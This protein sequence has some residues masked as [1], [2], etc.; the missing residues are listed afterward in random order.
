MGITKELLE[1][2]QGIADGN[3]TSFVVFGSRASGRERFD[4]DLDVMLIFKSFTQDIK[5]IET[6]ISDIEYDISS[7]YGISISSIQYSEKELKIGVERRDRL[8]L[9]MITGYKVIYDRNRFF[10]F[11]MERLKTSLKK[12]GAKY[13][14]KE[15]VWKIPRLKIRA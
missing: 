4:S 3:L 6:L 7:E 2:I 8:L 10:C 11:Q 5:K 9:G 14:E 15:R 13:I 12:Q 1:K